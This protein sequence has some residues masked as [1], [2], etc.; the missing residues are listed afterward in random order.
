MHHRYCVY[1]TTNKNKTTLY[2]G[3]TSNIQR[4]LQQHYEAS[5][6][7][8][9]TFTGRYNCY[10]LIYIEGFRSI[11]K[12]IQREKEIKKWRREKKLR[13][14][15]CFKPEWAFLNNHYL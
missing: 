13:L 7:G 9:K 10:Y 15:H 2:V 4:R 11:R 5:F 6:S 3:V 1:I 8:R 14:I 12:A